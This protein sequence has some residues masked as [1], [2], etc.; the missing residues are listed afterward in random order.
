[1]LRE[2]TLQ[3]PPLDFLQGT[4]IV[5]RCNSLYVET[6]IVLLAGVLIII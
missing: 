5:S 4:G 1:M 3:N 6:V 2:L